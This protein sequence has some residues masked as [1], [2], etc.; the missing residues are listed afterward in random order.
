MPADLC[1]R[2]SAYTEGHFT[3]FPQYNLLHFTLYTWSIQP[4]SSIGKRVEVGADL[5]FPGLTSRT[6]HLH[7]SL[8]INGYLDP[9]S[10]WKKPADSDQLN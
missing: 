7:P 9:S 4:W 3:L 8:F 2:A 6:P 5:S 10:S 1:P